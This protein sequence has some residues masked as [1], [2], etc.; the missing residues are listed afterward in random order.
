PASVP[1]LENIDQI[2]EI[3]VDEEAAKLAGRRFDTVAC[4]DDD[5]EACRIADH[6]NAGRRIGAYLDDGAVRY[7]DTAAPWYDMGLVSRFGKERADELKREN[8]R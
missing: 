2:Q 8:T 7:G 4:L 5:V 6:V 3:V 1:L